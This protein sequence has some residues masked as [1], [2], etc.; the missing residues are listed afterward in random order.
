MK[1]TI[2]IVVI[3]VLVIAA[4]FYVPVFCTVQQLLSPELGKNISFKRCYTISQHLRMN[5][6]R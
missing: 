1:N 6:G 3:I 4:L 5:Y 2:L